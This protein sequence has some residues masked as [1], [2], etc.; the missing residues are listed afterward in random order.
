MVAKRPLAAGPPGWTLTVQGSSSLVPC[1]RED[2]RFRVDAPGTPVVSG[3]VLCREALAASSVGHQ[4]ASLPPHVPATPP[5]A[6]TRGVP[7]RRPVSPWT[8]EWSRLRITSLG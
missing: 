1:R 4:A 7:G 8:A 3:W 5:A 6:T 2:G